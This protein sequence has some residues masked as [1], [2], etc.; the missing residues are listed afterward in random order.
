MVGLVDILTGGEDSPKVG[1]RG[2]LNLGEVG[3]VPVPVL[4]GV[5]LLV[6]DNKAWSKRWRYFD[7]ENLNGVVGLIVGGPNVALGTN[8]LVV[9]GPKGIDS[10]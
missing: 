7:R 2:K 5:P 10:L 1:G 4:L 8:P 6:I 9:M 3:G